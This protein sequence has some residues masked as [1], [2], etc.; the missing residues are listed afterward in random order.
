M[1]KW[2]LLASLAAAPAMAQQ[3]ASSVPEAKLVMLE[4]ESM[5]SWLGGVG[6]GDAGVGATDRL[7]AGLAG[8]RLPHHR[9]RLRGRAR[10]HRGLSVPSG[11]WHGRR[12]HA[13]RCR[14]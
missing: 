8:D 12:R 14:R 3:I 5:L 11:C 9:L 10:P 2:L 4:A 6:H 1:R 13:P 7:R